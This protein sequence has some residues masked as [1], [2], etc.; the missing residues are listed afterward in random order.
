MDPI[1]GTHDPPDRAPHGQSLN[2][3]N[4]NNVMLD[5]NSKNKINI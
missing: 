2:L 3:S 5:S 4:I 1:K